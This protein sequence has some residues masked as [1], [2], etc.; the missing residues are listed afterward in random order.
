MAVAGPRAALLD[1]RGVIYL[2]LGRSEPAVRDLEESV[3]E[4]NAAAG[5]AVA[6]T[7]LVGP[8]LYIKRDPV[9]PASGT[10]TYGNVG[11]DPTCSI[12]GQHDL[13]VIGVA[14]P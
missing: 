4:T 10:Y 14:V 3:A 11:V 6:S 8:D 13:A 9:C 1:T 5:D 2:A 12:G 7:D